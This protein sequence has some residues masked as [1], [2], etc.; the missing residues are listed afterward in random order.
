MT[1][2]P[3]II[4]VIMGDA[5]LRE[6]VVRLFRDAGFGVEV[7]KSGWAFLDW[8]VGDERACVVADMRLPD[9]TGVELE[10]ELHGRE[11]PLPM[12]LLVEE[13]NVEA[14]VEAMKFGANEVL[15]T[16][17]EP[18]RLL[19]AVAEALERDDREQAERQVLLE[20]QRRYASLTPRQ[21][22]VMAY[23]V[24]GRLNREIAVTLGTSEITIKLHRAKLLH[25]MQVKNAAELIH[26]ANRLS[27]KPRSRRMT[28]TP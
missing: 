25:R 4:Y 22:E 23:I 14:A 20:L 28:P 21:R 17:F 13:G 15:T 26:L 8:H 19:T 2:Q 1:A 27:S 6:A 12:V 16:P 5:S 24:E 11:R 7:I 9:M 3:S 18:D 10:R